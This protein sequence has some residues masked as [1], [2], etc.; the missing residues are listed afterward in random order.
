MGTALI[1]LLGIRLFAGLDQ[2]ET[3]LDLAEQGGELLAL[4]CGE[5]RQNLVFPPQQLREQ[6]LV[7]RAAL[8]RQLQ[9]E[10]TAVGFV[11]DPLDQAVMQQRGHRAADR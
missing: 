3:F 6:L 10:F 2:V 8:F 11:L 7:E 5:A 4:L 1:R 9:A